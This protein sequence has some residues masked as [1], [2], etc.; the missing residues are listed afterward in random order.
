V[1]VLDAHGHLLFMNRNGLCVMEIDDFDEV[2]GKPWPT[3][4][5][6]ESRQLVR[7]A[8]ESASRGGLGHFIAE[9]PTAKG[10]PKWWDVTVAAV[11]YGPQ[12]RLISISRDVT[13]QRKAEEVLKASNE[14]M[15]IAAHEMAHRINNTLAVVQSIIGQTARTTPDPKEFAAAVSTR[16]AAMAKANRALAEGNWN[17]ANLEALVRQELGAHISE[18]DPRLHLTGPE[19]ALPPSA[20]T[21]FAL[22]IHELA[23]NAVKY[24]A[25]VGEAGAV[26]I[27]WTVTPDERGRTTLTVLWRERGGPPVKTPTRRGFGSILLDRGIDDCKVERRFDPE[28]VTCRIVLGL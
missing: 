22:L 3:L 12:L 9:C 20:V 8:M 24:G 23:T 14:Q 6:D 18:S 21:A 1:K 15:K 7:D 19:I 16:I 17:G 11:P 28:G 26:D 25:L 4:W 5:P 13:L 2:R 27:T 10:T